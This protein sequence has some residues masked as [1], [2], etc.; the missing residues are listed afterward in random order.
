M[1]R[2]ATA[3]DAC[4]PDSRHHSSRGHATELLDQAQLI[5]WLSKPDDRTVQV[6]QGCA[7]HQMTT[8]RPS[9][10]PSRDINVRLGVLRPN[11]IGSDALALPRGE[12]AG[13]PVSQL[14]RITAWLIWVSLVAVSSVTLLCAANS[15][16]RSA[17]S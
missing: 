2:C 16:S 15:R 12:P 4:V 14:S 9:Q 7:G 11:V 8:F 6:G 13:Y 1:G 5:G 17:A 10:Q 3:G